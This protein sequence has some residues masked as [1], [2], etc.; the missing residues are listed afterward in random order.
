ML[1]SRERLRKL[2]ARLNAAREEERT[3]I[4][5]DIHDEL[6]QTLTG[7]KMDLAW[8]EERL[9]AKLPAKNREAFVNRVRTMITLVDTTISFVRRLS[10]S[11]RPAMLDDLGLEAAIDW[12][13]RGFAERTGYDYTIELTSENLGADHK[14]E[15]AMF[16]IFQEALTNVARHAGAT[17]VDVVLRKRDSQLVLKIRDNGCG[18]EAAQ[19]DSNQSLGLIGMQERALMCG[20]ELRI[21]RLAQGGGTEVTLTMPIDGSMA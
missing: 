21:E 18:I 10:S 1:E 8:L 6:G 15:T 2:A 16:R 13:L 9:A 5:R 7:L 12:Q 4:A 17:H 19:L 14:L 3:R 11:L 20:G